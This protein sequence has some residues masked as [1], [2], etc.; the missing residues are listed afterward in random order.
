[1]ASRELLMETIGAAIALGSARDGARAGNKKKAKRE[2][3][4]FV[5]RESFLLETCS[6]TGANMPWDRYSRWFEQMDANPM[7]LAGDIETGGGLLADIVKNC[8]E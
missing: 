3:Q 6:I 2:W 5:K 8:K 1:M 4:N 7:R